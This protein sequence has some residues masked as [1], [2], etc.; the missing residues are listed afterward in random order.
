MTVSSVRKRK[1]EVKVGRAPV[2]WVK[3]SVVNTRQY[4]EG[5]R[6]ETGP[7][8]PVTKYQLKFP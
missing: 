8:R 1:Q 2:Q 5:V 4:S 6:G 3:S 7:N